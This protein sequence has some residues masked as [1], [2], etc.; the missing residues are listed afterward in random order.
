M[1]PTWAADW[2]PLTHEPTAEEMQALFD[3]LTYADVAKTIDQ[4]RKSVV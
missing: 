3:K 1:I 2:T 4:D